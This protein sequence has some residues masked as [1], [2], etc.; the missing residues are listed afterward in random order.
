MPLWAPIHYLCFAFLSSYIVVCRALQMVL[1][2]AGKGQTF[3]KQ[4]TNNGQDPHVSQAQRSKFCSGDFATDTEQCNQHRRK[5]FHSY[6]IVAQQ[7]LNPVSF[8]YQSRK[9]EPIQSI[10]REKMRLMQARE[11]ICP[12]HSNVWIKRTT[13]GWGFMLVPEPTQAAHRNLMARSDAPLF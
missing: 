5:W 3:N 6:F 2:C 4:S 1:I 9:T 10:W 11:T 12:S 8:A 7:F 13:A